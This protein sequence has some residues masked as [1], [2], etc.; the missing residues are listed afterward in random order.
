MSSTITG[1]GFDEQRSIEDPTKPINISELARLT[2]GD[3]PTANLPAVSPGTAM[4][5]SA[6]RACVWCIASAI[7]RMPLITYRRAES[8]SRER[9]KDHANYRLFRLRPNPDMSAT[10]FLRAVMTNALLW[11]NGYAEIVRDS[12]QRITGYVPVESWRVTP[13]RING[14]L[15]YRVQTDG[16]Q[17]TLLKRD[18]IHIPGLSYNG[19][20]GLS[21]IAHARMTLAAAISASSYEA[22]LL[23]N[24][25][26]PSGVLQ[27]PG[28]LGKDGQNNLRESFTHTYAGSANAGKFMI[29]EEGMEWKPNAMPLADAQ[30]IEGNYFRIEE[31]CRWFNV[32]P[33]K[34]QHLLRSTNN[35]IEQQS[36]DF[37][38]DTISPWTESIQQEINYKAFDELE[39][40]ELYVEF[41]TQ[42]LV[43]MD[44]TTRGGLYSKLFGIAAISSDEVRERENLNHLPDNRGDVYYVPSNMMP[45]PT[46]EEATKLLSSWTAKAPGAGQPKSEADGKVAGN[47]SPS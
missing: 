2:D 29:L 47:G 16:E 37:L 32:P 27:H 26:R 11:G 42:V 34:I 23:A 7:A 14:E 45:A 28:R 13:K 33:H 12:R 35:N 8:G 25:L 17:V 18:M 10:S 1:P 22:T 19:I 3:Y 5:I 41:L 36:L 40:D 4:R 31:I 43:Q 21:V 20:V 38:G 6:V 39:Q 30:F 46:P 44:A 24:G 15:C 9:A